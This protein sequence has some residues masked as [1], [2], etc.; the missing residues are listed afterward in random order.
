MQKRK[1]FL[2]SLL[3]VVGVGLSLFLY[4]ERDYFNAQPLD[5]E[6]RLDSPSFSVSD[7][8][9][10][11]YVIDRALRRIVKITPDG[12]VAA[13]I[14]GGKRG[15][16]TF[17]YATELAVDREGNLYAINNHL[18][19]PLHLDAGVKPSAGQFVRSFQEDT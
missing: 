1:W 3:L 17:F 16:N 4:A 13:V 18:V 2:L 9:D 15:T 6:F 11:L 12:R 19:M 14:N 5:F 8:D 7:K 10:N